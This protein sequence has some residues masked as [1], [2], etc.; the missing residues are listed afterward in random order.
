MYLIAANYLS[1]SHHANKNKFKKNDKGWGGER[2]R[3]VIH[4]IIANTFSNFTK[5]K[6]I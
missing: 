6:L 2:E 3:E 5:P 4:K 1:R